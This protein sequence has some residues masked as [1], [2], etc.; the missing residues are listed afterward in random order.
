[1]TEPPPDRG[2][3][4]TVTHVR[5]LVEE[6]ERCFR[7]YAEDLG[8]EATFGDAT[9]GYAD[10]DTGDVTL[11]LHAVEEMAAALGDD[12]GADRGRDAAALI[13]RVDDVD[14]AYADLADADC[15]RVGAPQDRPEWGIRVAHVR[16]PDGTLVEVNE[17]IEG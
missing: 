16:D 11:A 3:D 1:M 9:S 5:L 17:P 7:F 2:M 10:F 12:G 13:L 14:A 6:Y 8:Y 15:E 4:A